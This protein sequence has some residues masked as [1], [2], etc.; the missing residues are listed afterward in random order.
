MFSGASV[1]GSILESIRE[2]RRF[3]Q[4]ARDP[5]VKM[6]ARE[7]LEQFIRG[8]VQGNASTEQDF[9]SLSR[10]L[11]QL[12]AGA[13]E[14]T[15]V[16]RERAAG[17]R[18]AL[19][20]SRLTGEDSLS[21]KMIGDVHA[22]LAE[23]D[24]LLHSLSDVGDAL[25]D[26][27]SGTHSIK[28]IG[29]Y[30]NSS[31]VSFAI[32]SCRTPDCQQAFSSFVSE[33][34]TLAGNVSSLADEI[35]RELERTSESQAQTMQKLSAGLQGIRQL[36]REIDAAARTTAG[37]A[38]QL[39]DQSLAA[40]HE[41]EDCARKIAQHA[42]D[43]VYHLQF[44]DIIRQKAEHIASA[45][46]EAVGLL[47]TDTPGSDKAAASEHV[48][49]IQMSQLESVRDEVLDAHGK[50]TT[51]FQRIAA[52]THRLA[53]ALKAGQ[54][55]ASRN[56]NASGTLEE[57]A[58][59]TRRMEE[60]QQEGRR[61]GRQAQATAAQAAAASSQVA[62]HFDRVSVIN[63]ELHLQALN[64]IVKTSALGTQG[65]TL[66]VLSSQVDRLFRESSV[67]VNGIR[68]TLDRIEPHAEQFLSTQSDEA[69][70]PQTSPGQSDVMLGLE[71]IGAAYRELSETT[72]QAEHLA[73][74][75]ETWLENNRQ[76]LDFLCSLA[77]AMSEQIR[78][79]GALRNEIVP[80]AAESRA[81]SAA[82][83]EALDKRY[84]MQS[85]REI[86]ARVSG[87]ATS[88]RSAAREASP[89]ANLD[90]F[91]APSPIED[92]PAVRGAISPPP[93]E[94]EGT[95]E[96]DQ[97]R[98]SPAESIKA[99]DTGFGENIELF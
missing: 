99:S 26:L 55:P 52:E 78:E 14:L 63:F 61:L 39:L 73:V 90:L 38:Q 37:E 66:E 53:E 18:T 82:T 46:Q 76:H 86:H 4:K 65:A 32:E 43:A 27:Q 33:L 15:G 21:S 5:A 7:G 8:F 80:W 60:L 79:L 34:R 31:V 58:M 70:N 93:T 19:E 35:G 17:L 29:V 97:K 3:L 40:L 68:Q 95:S 96:V 67:E 48:L 98:P 10:T 6:T 25:N 30:L 87:A 54:E 45:L 13:T 94:S 22:S 41:A 71:A 62:R 47:S 36:S 85:E 84:T 77:E 57:F 28:R 50:L 16:V 23:V 42:D 74:E 49:A 89:D 56:G 91:D 81:P 9:V 59:Q 2:W 1:R 64:A 72:A 44:G 69:T 24:R 92:A 20:R 12:Y 88:G 51:C 11:R 75:E 83:L